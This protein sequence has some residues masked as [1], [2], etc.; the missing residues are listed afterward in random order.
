MC[1]IGKRSD[2]GRFLIR[3]ISVFV[4]AWLG[5]GVFAPPAT[6]QRTDMDHGQLPVPIGAQGL[7]GGG[8]AA[9]EQQQEAL[10]Q[11]MLRNPADLKTGLA[12]A[13]LSARLG[14]NEAA[15]TALERM[16]IYNPN[17]ANIDL[18]LGALY[19]RMGSFEIAQTY[20]DKALAN[21]PS[22][23]VAA[24]ARRYLDAAGSRE[25]PHQ[26]VGQLLVGAQYQS[27]ANVAPAA[28]FLESQI[29]TVPLGRRSVK[30][31]ALNTFAAGTVM[32]SYD[33]GTQ[34]RDA[35]EVGGTALINHYI[36]HGRLD[37]GFAEVTAGPRLRF[38]DTGLWWAP[39]GSLKPYLIANEAG[40]GEEQY[41]YSYG[42]GLE[43]TTV[44]PGDVVAK[45]AFEFRQKTFSSHPD[46]P[47]ARG[48]SGSDKLVSLTLSKAITANSTLSGE[49]DYLDQGARFRFY[50]NK[51]YA[52][53]GSYRIRYD[54]PAGWQSQPW[55]TT[56][57][58]SH[59]WAY[60][61]APDPCCNSSGSA[62]ISL[63][64]TRRDGDWRFG[65]TQ[66][67]PVTD[68]M[69]VVVQV[70]RDILSS[71]LQLYG[72]TSTSALA[73]LKILF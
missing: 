69:A 72:Y 4:G 32:Y 19:F 44:L 38:P 14:N 40:L 64:S 50:A 10:F 3:C 24:Q 2:R 46:I 13:E 51:S 58:A 30:E 71:N 62:A 37:V 53:G 65:V 29:G 68:T 9:L 52:L 34:D 12:Y 39:S 23:E 61:E 56:F 60:Y 63:P 43:G 49:F 25:S 55:D 20:F 33:L 42:T 41:F 47:N 57:Y 45:A 5:C 1:G 8:N 31:N 35:L 59:S 26:I 17:L 67:I 48:L 6:A 66:S 27:D 18:E 36:N 16:L 70:Q 15:V 22:P 11:Q 7:A 28:S 73:G 21:H 54:D